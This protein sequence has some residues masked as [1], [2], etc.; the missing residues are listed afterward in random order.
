MWSLGVGLAN[1]LGGSGLRLSLMSAHDKM[2][3]A[4]AHDRVIW[5]RLNKL[6]A[7]LEKGC[8]PAQWT[9]VMDLLRSLTRLNP[10]ERLTAAEVLQHPFL[11]KADMLARLYSS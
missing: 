7:A 9:D 11:K 5:T 1:V 3:F 10:Q 6:P 8:V 4:E 2:L